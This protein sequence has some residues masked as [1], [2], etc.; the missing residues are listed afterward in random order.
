MQ[1]GNLLLRLGSCLLGWNPS[2]LILTA[3]NNYD[4]QKYQSRELLTPLLA[5]L[6]SGSLSGF[7]SKCHL[8]WTEVSVQGAP[9]S[10]AC[11]AG[12]P[13]DLVLIVRVIYY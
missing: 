9:V 13:V 11:W 3:S 10:L 4:R 12:I 7:N 2:L 6:E 5:G 8:L 1:L